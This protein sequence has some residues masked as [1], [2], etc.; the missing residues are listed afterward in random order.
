LRSQEEASDE[1]YN[2]RENDDENEEQD[3]LEEPE[4][5][6]GNEPR[7]QRPEIE[8]RGG[9]ARRRIVSDWSLL[10]PNSIVSLKRIRR[11]P[12]VIVLESDE[13]TEVRPNLTLRGFLKSL[14]TTTDL[15][16]LA[17][18]LRKI[19]I[20]GVEQL[21]GHARRGMDQ[22]IEELKN[23]RPPVGFGHREG[24]RFAL[25]DYLV[26]NERN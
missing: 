16:V 22:M 21:K 15:L 2:P 4:E 1:E 7:E 3:E 6:G 11:Q 24:L 12:S 17:G 14:S 20:V 25:E 10:S 8:N 23:L 19:K 18:P 5:E 26:K 9:P 13:E